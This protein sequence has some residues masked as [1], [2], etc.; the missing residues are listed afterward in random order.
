[1]PPVARRERRAGAAG[2]EAGRGELEVDLVRNGVGA[3]N[4]APGRGVL[5]HDVVDGVAAH[6]VVAAQV[7]A[8]AEQATQG[9]VVEA[10]ERFRER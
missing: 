8:G 1:M 3:A 9:P 2:R 4:L 10:G 7:G 5:D 6:V